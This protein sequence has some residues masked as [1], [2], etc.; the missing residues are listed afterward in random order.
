MSL[1]VLLSI[2]HGGTQTPP[3][4]QYITCISE[5]DILQDGDAYT[6]QIYDM[7]E[8]AAVVVRAGVA[9]AFVDV[10]RSLRDM[11]PSNPDGLIKSAT[12]YQRPIYTTQPDYEL[13]RTLV[14][15]HYMPYHRAIQRGM[16]EDIQ[17]CIDC[18][19]MAASPP[20]VSPD[21]KHTSRPL[22]CL[23]NCNGQTCSQEAL[24]RLAGGISAAYGVDISEIRFNDPF[25][26]G[27]ITRTYG[28]NPLPWIQVEVNHSMYL[29][30][31]WPA[32]APAESRLRE[33]RSMFAEAVRM[34]F[35]S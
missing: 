30:A 33:M 16:R 26:G 20:P 14:Q 21:A 18:H 2:P 13:R 7:G 1:P 29:P 15:N 11:P 19:S 4:V 23:S 28:G 6:L 35:G 24:E 32:E 9:R 5:R 17:L 34:Y 12:C 25:L 8:E 31:A 10:N 27:H 3:E 22:F